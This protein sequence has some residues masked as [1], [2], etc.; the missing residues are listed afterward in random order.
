[1]KRGKERTS[2]QPS[3]RLSPLVFVKKVKNSRSNPELKQQIQDIFDGRMQSS[4]DLF[5]L[6]LPLNT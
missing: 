6:G 1:M 2:R 4:K 5:Y 3:N